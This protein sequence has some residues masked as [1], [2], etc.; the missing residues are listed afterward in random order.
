[1]IKN[2]SY[3][4]EYWF[5][6]NDKIGIEKTPFQELQTECMGNEI[7]TLFQNIIEILVT[8]HELF[9][10]DEYG[11]E[12]ETSPKSSVIH[13]TGARVSIMIGFNLSK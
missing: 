6:N 1:M 13:P 4:R 7:H 11:I 2:L 12:E 5:K 8:S 3:A 9:E 10:Y